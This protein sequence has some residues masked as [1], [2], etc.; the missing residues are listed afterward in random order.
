MASNR[1]WEPL[2]GALIAILAAAIG[3]GGTLAGNQLANVH[4]RAQ[5][6]AQFAHDESTRQDDVRRKAYSRFISAVSEYQNDLTIEAD[7]L[8]DAPTPSKAVI[9]EILT[10]SAQVRTAWAEVQVVGGTK[11]TRLATVVREALD[12]V[13]QLD[14]L[15][16]DKVFYIAQRDSQYKLDAF[17]DA[18]RKELNG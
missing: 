11:T 7:H 15:I 9:S 18:A 2:W 4:A 8:R 12:A 17:L 3:A 14:P 1:R 5:L 13:L 10:D 16:R 6:A